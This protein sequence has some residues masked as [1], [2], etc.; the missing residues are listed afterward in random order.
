MGISSKKALLS[1]LEILLIHLLKYKFQAK[2]RTRSWFLT[3]KEHRRRINKAFKETP[4]LKN[5]LPEI[6]LKVYQNAR[7]EASTQTKLPVDIFSTQCPFTLENI[8]NPDY[9][10]E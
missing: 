5:Y 6:F 1:N 2:K 8:L 7:E 3:I 10:P 9:L 4:S